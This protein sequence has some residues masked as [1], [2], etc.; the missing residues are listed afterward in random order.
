MRSAF[1]AATAFA[2]LGLA[3]AS[4]GTRFVVRIANIPYDV[5]IE[6]GERIKARLDATYAGAN[7]SFVGAPAPPRPPPDPPTPPRP[8]P[9]PAPP[10]PSPPPTPPSSPPPPDAPPS[11]PPPSPP[12]AVDSYPFKLRVRKTEG[13]YDVFD[14]ELVQQ[15][16][17]LPA[18]EENFVTAVHDGDDNSGLRISATPFVQTGTYQVSNE[19]GSYTTQAYLPDVPRTLVQSLD[20]AAAGTPDLDATSFVSMRRL[21]GSVCLPVDQPVYSGAGAD[22]D[23][24]F[25]DVPAGESLVYDV[26][27]PADTAAYAACH[28]LSEASPL[29][30]LARVSVSPGSG[31]DT[32]I[33][34]EVAPFSTASTDG[35]GL[36]EFVLTGTPALDGFVDIS[37]SSVG[38]F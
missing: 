11:P 20:T 18:A 15:G 19:F 14:L 13:T 28:A 4:A 36:Y 21:A 7:V 34:V 9:P 23:V 22:A 8:P 30:H 27:R 6:A 35:A 1:Y 25:F 32:S 24:L 31:I 16:G 33:F 29:V 37:A 10:P 2:L 3:S 5:E 17:T 38:E 12:P 26:Q